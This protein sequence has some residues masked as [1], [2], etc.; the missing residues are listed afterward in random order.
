MS[1]GRVPPPLLVNPADPAR[2]AWDSLAKHPLLDGVLIE[3]I[4]LS[5][6]T[7]YTRVPHNLGRKY[8]GYL[9]VR[10]VGLIE[11]QSNPRKDKEIWLYQERSPVLLDY[12]EVTGADVGT[13]TFSNLQ[14]DKDLVYQMI[15][16]IVNNSGV[17]REYIINP[18]GVATAQDSIRITS[19]GAAVTTAAVTTGLW[20]FQGSAN[21]WVDVRLYAETGQDRA[22]ISFGSRDNTGVTNIFTGNWDETTTEITSLNV[23]CSGASE[24]GVGSKFWLY[25]LGNRATVA[26]IYLF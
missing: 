5:T 7:K 20:I 12:H 15:A 18:N 17:A 6:T 1:T 2:P 21:G 24:I 13:V 3:D 16:Y 19:D 11:D 22:H 25:A 23:V 8:K 10:G 26:S 9:D 14:G 4:T